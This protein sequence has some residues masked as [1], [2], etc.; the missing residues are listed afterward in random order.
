MRRRNE[1]TTLALV[2]RPGLS[3]HT[4]G[5]EHGATEWGEKH[6]KTP[7]F[8]I[9][10]AVIRKGCRGFALTSLFWLHDERRCY[11][12]HLVPS[13]RTPFR[14][15][16]CGASRSGGSTK[17]IL[18]LRSVGYRCTGWE[19]IRMTR[20]GSLRQAQTAREC[21]G[22]RRKVAHVD[23]GSLSCIVSVLVSAGSGRSAGPVTEKCVAFTLCILAYGILAGC[24]MRRKSFSVGMKMR[25]QGDSAKWRYR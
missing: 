1:A 25:I 13:L 19:K 8:F 3:P 14:Q 11:K 4:T 17:H 24:G 9:T 7:L 18:S 10:G 22:F 23:P 15:G 21:R 5:R 6:P 2:H 16:F 20:C 12:T